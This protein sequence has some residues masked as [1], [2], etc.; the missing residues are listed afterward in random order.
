MHRASA[1]LIFLFTPLHYYESTFILILWIN[2]S[3]I[4]AQSLLLVM[5]AISTTK[6]VHVVAL[7]GYEA[8]PCDSGVEHS[9]QKLQEAAKDLEPFVTADFD[10]ITVTV[11]PCRSEE[12]T[13]GYRCVC[14][15]QLVFQD[16]RFQ[17]AMRH[18][19]EPVVLG[20]DTFPVATQRI[21]LAMKQLLDYINQNQE[22]LQVMATYL[23]SVSF[24]SSWIDTPTCDCFVT[25]LY[26]NPVDEQLWKDRAQNVCHALSLARLIGR[27]K[28]RVF[29]VSGPDS[30]AYLNDEVYLHLHQTTNASNRNRV[31]LSIEDVPETACI[32]VTVHYQK[33]ETAFFHPN[34]RA[35]LQALEWMMGRLQHINIGTSSCS[36]LEMYCGCGAHTVA[37]AKSGYVHSIVAVELDN[38]LVQ[39]C[40]TNCKLNGCHG[41]ESQEGV[42]P[43]HVFQGDASEWAHKSIK[44]TS[45]WY[46]KEYSILLVDPPRM[47]LAENV[48][49]MAM[50]GTFQHVLYVSCGRHALKRDLERL[51]DTFEVVDCH[52]LDLFP[53]TDAVESL[54]HLKRRVT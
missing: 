51:K 44:K 7:P 43:V 26:G 12:E 50:Q 52:L 1:P 34:S 3:V 22:T 31:T 30:H 17:Y 20:T 4:I 47:G 48:C 37:L 28:G 32:P 18:Q 14:T 29:F 10:N 41:D 33:P 16:D 40:I 23:T 35:M 39:A 5:T 45:G 38:R 19:K 21:Q 53:R 25:L 2:H 27:S 24:A 15:F 6:S 54:V 49:Q 13:W 42:S 8:Q 36:M 46:D 11:A 9:R